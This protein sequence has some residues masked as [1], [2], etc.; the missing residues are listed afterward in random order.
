MDT[1]LTPTNA[2]KVIDEALKVAQKAGV[3]SFRDSAVI[4]SSML[5]IERCVKSQTETPRSKKAET[6]Q[7]ESEAKPKESIKE[8]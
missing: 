5:V 4:Y 6:S 7:T 1:V 8:I 2:L 3:Y